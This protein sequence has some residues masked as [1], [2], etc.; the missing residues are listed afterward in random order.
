MVRGARLQFAA[1]RDQELQLASRFAGRVDGFLAPLQEAL[2]VGE[3]PLFLHVRRRGKEEDLGVDV[4][5]RLF[6]EHGGLGLDEVADDE[7]FELAEGGAFEL[8]VRRADRGVLAHDEEAIELAIRHVQPVAKVRVIAGQARQPLEA[9]AVLRRGGV[10]VVRLQQRDDVLVE[11]VP[12]PFRGAV[13][14]DV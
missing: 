10:A 6:P 9:E 14:L 7:P 12:P 2:G 13:L 8:R 1:E 5:G 3:R 11:V 4:V